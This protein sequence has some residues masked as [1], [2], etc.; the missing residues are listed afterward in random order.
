MPFKTKQRYQ[1]AAGQFIGCRETTKQRK[2]ADPVTTPQSN[3]TG[4]HMEC[5]PG[6]KAETPDYVSEAAT[7]S[8]V[9]YHLVCKEMTTGDAT[10]TKWGQ[11]GCMQATC[12]LAKPHKK[13]DLAGNIVGCHAEP[14]C[15]VTTA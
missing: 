5:L 10:C 2:V 6:Y 11:T 4:N 15:P 14:Y 7:G 1:N 9:K 3:Y 12:P 13:M 8:N